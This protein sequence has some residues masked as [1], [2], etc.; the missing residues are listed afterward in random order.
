MP[1]HKEINSILEECS[2]NLDY[3]AELIRDLPLDPARENIHRIGRAISK[4]FEIR[5]ELFKVDPS[6]KPQGWDEPPTSAE[7]NRMFGKA[8]LQAQTFCESGNHLEAIKTFESF[9]F[10]GP[11]EEFEHMAKNEIKKL[12]QQYGV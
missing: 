8:I 2:S 6:L 11:P 10:I 1:T 12:N 5:E 4:I 9:I 3:C 7:Y